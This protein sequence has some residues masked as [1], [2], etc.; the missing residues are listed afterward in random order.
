MPNATTAADWDRAV[1]RAQDAAIGRSGARP[2]GPRRVAPLRRPAG[3]TW[4]ESAG[5]MTEVLDWHVK[6][7]PDLESIRIL[8]NDQDSP[9]IHL[10]Y[11]ALAD[12]ASAIA[13]GLLAAGLDRGDRIAIMLPTAQPVPLW[14]GR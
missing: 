11:G 9:V 1:R 5:T 4:P 7:H 12:A 10:S 13:F 8:G 14:P 6:V 2:N 3:E